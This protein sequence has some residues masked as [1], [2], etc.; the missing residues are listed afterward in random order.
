MCAAQVL[1]VFVG[2]PA[3]RIANAPEGTM[4]PQGPVLWAVA[5]LLGFTSIPVGVVIRLI[6]DSLLLKLIPDYL[7]RSRNVPGLA[8]TD[9]ETFESYPAVLG[10][11]RDELQ[12]LR[13]LKGG[14]LNNLRYVMTHPKEIIV[15]SRSASHSRSNSSAHV[16]PAPGPK[17]SLGSSGGGPAPLGMGDARMRSWSTRSRSS[18]ALGAPTVMAGI[19]AAGIATNWSPADRSPSREEMAGERK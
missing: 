5:I 13:R 2:G 11:V 10:E 1:I 9:A 3:F 15:R 12:F 4:D 8:V 7:K 6:P 16:P 19:V 17:D 14:R 18:S